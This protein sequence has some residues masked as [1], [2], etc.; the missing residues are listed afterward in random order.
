MRNNEIIYSKN[1]WVW[2]QNSP[3]SEVTL[4]RFS[5]GI[6]SESKKKKKQHLTKQTTAGIN[7]IQMILF[8]AF[9]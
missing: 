6:H 7:Y 5:Q 1:A 4:V 2:I 3:C 9:F 8:L